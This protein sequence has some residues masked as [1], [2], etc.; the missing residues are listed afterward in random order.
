MVNRT[1]KELQILRKIVVS[2]QTVE[3]CFIQMGSWKDKEN[4][5]HPFIFSEQDGEVASIKFNLEKIYDIFT[6]KGSLLHSFW[7]SMITHFEDTTEIDFLMLISY[8]YMITK[9]GSDRN[10]QTATEIA[11]I[12]FTTYQIDSESIQEAIKEPSKQNLTQKKILANE[13]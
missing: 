4:L 10:V 1:Q 6:D 11:A 9:N 2:K 13:V 12:L 3:E 5:I 7:D 8:V